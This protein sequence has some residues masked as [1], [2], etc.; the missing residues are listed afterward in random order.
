MRRVRDSAAGATTQVGYGIADA[1]GEGP[2]SR[3]KPPIAD[4]DGL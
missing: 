3:V 1:S 4:A 2:P